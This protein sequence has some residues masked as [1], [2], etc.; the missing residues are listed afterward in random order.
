MKNKIVKYARFFLLAF[1][2]FF[3]FNWFLS[4]VFKV[5]MY[6]SFSQEEKLAVENK[7]QERSLY[8]ES[9]SPRP[10]QSESNP[11][12][13]SL[14][15]AYNNVAYQTLGSVV[16]LQVESEAQVNNSPFNNDE[17]LK[18]FFGL[19]RNNPQ[20][21]RRA[22]SYGSGFIISPD[23]FLLSNFHVIK[24]ATKIKIVFKDSEKEYTAS[25]VGSDEDTDIALLKIDSNESFPFLKLAN[26]DEVRI[27]DIVVAIGNPFGLS[28]T[29]TTGVVSAKGR[30]GVIGNRY[31]DFIQTDVAINPGNSGGPL[32]NLLG[33]VIGINSAILSR[34]GGSIGIGFSIPINMA[35]NILED[36]KTSGKVT[37]GWIGI[38]FQEISEDLAEA[39]NVSR[40][41]IVITRVIEES[42]AS[43]ADVEAGDILSEFNG[44]RIKNGRDLIN[45]L[46]AVKVGER[47]SLTLLRDGKTVR[48]RIT[49]LERAED[50]VASQGNDND[51]RGNQGVKV[52]DY[53]GIE[54]VN[55]DKE[56][57][58][59]Y[60]VNSA[61]G[62]LVSSISRNSALTEKGLR[63]GDL[64][65]SINKKPTINTSSYKRVAAEVK[66]GQKVLFTV[67]REER[68]FYLVIDV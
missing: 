63:V 66:K 2:V 10:V 30:V 12:L 4:E 37:R 52:G 44:Q 23:G 58:E 18:R 46:A 34:S 21:R 29:F 35:K 11:S 28:H 27:G 60:K 1:V 57:L 61:V 40:N 19:P 24:D 50:Q 39:L 6:D 47:A 36:L 8:Q 7:S 14:Q 64:I 51:F 16:S 22:E 68:I 38:E 59:R 26:S 13:L 33:E 5:N 55:M 53:F 41:G 62:V 56:A 65:K 3:G 31:E 49:I 43:K 9:N 48:T 67:Q 54:V 20:Q 32:L 17:F 15:Q 45:K 25:V 42:P